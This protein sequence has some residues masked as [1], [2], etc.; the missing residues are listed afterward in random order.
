MMPRWKTADVRGGT[1]GVIRGTLALGLALAAALAFAVPAQA[2]FPGANGK[3]AY[4]SCGSDDCG[5]FT[6]NPDG[7]G[8]TQVTHNPL[9]GATRFG[10]YDA[11]D[12]FP[13]WSPDGKRIAFARYGSAPAD[14]DIHSDIYV[15]NAD[16]TGVTQL[17]TAGYVESE[18]TWSPDGEH[19]AFIS[20]ITEPSGFSKYV[21]Y[22]VNADGSDQH[23]VA[24]SRVYLTSP[25]WSPKGD[26]IAVVAA[27]DGSASGNT[28]IHTVRP[29]G[30]GEVPV[31]D[32]VPDAPPAYIVD[33]SWS[34]DASRL[35]FGR[36][37][38]V[39]DSP[40]CRYET[41][42]AT[43]GANGNGLTNLTPNTFDREDEEPAWS[44]DGTKI[45]YVSNGQIRVMNSDGS[46]NVAI[47]GGHD[48]GWQPIVNGSPD[49]SGV[50]PTPTT[51]RS[52][53]H[54]F[55]TVDLSGATD[56]DGD[57][58][59]ITIDGVTQDEPVGN[60]ADARRALRS[61]QVELRAERDNKGDGRVYRIAFTASDG[62]GGECSS[63]AAVEVRPK[64]KQ[65]A[66]DSAPPSYDSFGQ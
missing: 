62:N 48:P 36:A 60:R 31:T 47:G 41:D 26:L 35:A 34:P 55:R 37:D 22:I 13:A 28:E 61:N 43:I 17:T 9:M 33:P 56:P 12:E 45:V 57:A 20:F 11:P 63:V 7:S 21:L 32:A 1:M 58:V 14:F 51:L 15:A 5:V 10:S 4:S 24:E 53:G 66:V 42:V 8:V 52:H 49:C 40:C 6:M 25:D 46:D 30:T 54:D 18:P 2:T 3:I 39:P 16:G 23:P 64:K 59:S 38:Y 65:A 44:P 27:G 19:I 50:T 29:D